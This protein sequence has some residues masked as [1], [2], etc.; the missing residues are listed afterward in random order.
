[1]VLAAPDA[2]EPRLVAS[3][4]WQLR[5]DPR[6]AFVR[7]QIEVAGDA[8]D[9]AWAAAFARSER[10]RVAHEAEWT[11]ELRRIT[12]ALRCVRFARG[13]V[14]H[15]DLVFPGRP[16][17]DWLE[18]L[19]R[20]A[21]IRSAA[22]RFTDRPELPTLLD[23]AER[24]GIDA[25]DLDLDGAWFARPWRPSPLRSLVL[26][27]FPTILVTR[28]ARAWEPGQLRRLGLRDRK[29]TPPMLD[30]IVGDGTVDGLERLDLLGVGADAELV[31]R[32]VRRSSDAPIALSLS[33]N[34]ALRGQGADWIERVLGWRPLS[35]LDLGGQT[36]DDVVVRRLFDE[37]AFGSLVSLGLGGPLPRHRRLRDLELPALRRLSL[38]AP[39]GPAVADEIAA[40]PG[41]HRLLALGLAGTR[42]G[43]AGVAALVGCRF[44]RLVELDLRD[45]HLTDDALIRLAAW[46]SLEHLVRLRLAGNPE[47]TGEG[48]RALMA[49]PHF[50]PA[51]LEVGTSVRWTPRLW[52]DLVASYGPAAVTELGA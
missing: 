14:E 9:A 23:A 36:S 4:L 28:V 41:L 46:P 48:W 12:P 45:N 18:L 17:L 39:G 52:D 31:R 38:G 34:P 2:D 13:F 35:G 50:R 10:L 42:I 37:P 44:D 20:R 43:D 51:V 32:L 5:E 8:G 26:R 24:A 3:D 19:A 22:I 33:G 25:L 1:M 27:R 47:L 30:P 7:A 15:V 11:R 49:A 6:G 16:D 29:L 21:P 40:A